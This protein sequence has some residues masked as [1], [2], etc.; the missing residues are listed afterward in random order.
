MIE[1]K[2]IQKRP[3]RNKLLPQVQSKLRYVYIN[4]NCGNFDTTNFEYNQLVNSS[5][6]RQE[7]IDII[8]ELED[9]VG[10]LFLVYFQKI[11]TFVFL[12]L[13]TTA[14]MIIIFLLLDRNQK[15]NIVW[16]LTNIFIY[17]ILEAGFIFYLITSIIKLRLSNS[18]EIRVFLDQINKNIYMDRGI[19]WSFHKSKICIDL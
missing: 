1:V 5:L 14:I 16:V 11:A 3:L 9:L 12:T 10:N 8:D 2:D 7:V 17:I 15:N 13:I 18:K 19:N 4:K 6:D